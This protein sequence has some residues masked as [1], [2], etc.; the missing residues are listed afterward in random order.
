[1]RGRSREWERLIQWRSVRLRGSGQKEGSGTE[2]GGRQRG[3]PS[4]RVETHI[5]EDRQLCVWE[6]YGGGGEKQSP[7]RAGGLKT[8]EANKKMGGSHSGGL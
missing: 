1:M 5:V 6:A 8:W 3:R 7:K 2:N 4:E